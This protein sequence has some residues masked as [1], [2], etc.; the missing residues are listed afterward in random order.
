MQCFDS[1]IFFFFPI[2][3]LNRHKM[4]DGSDQENEE[5]VRQMRMLEEL[6]QL[7]T[8]C[9]ESIHDPVLRNN[10]ISLAS[11]FS[12]AKRLPLYRLLAAVEWKNEIVYKYYAILSNT[13]LEL[14]QRIIDLMNEFVS[15]S[16][17]EVFMNSFHSLKR[18]RIIE[19]LTSIKKDQ[20]HDMLQILRHST[21]SDIEQ[22]SDLINSL[23]FK[24][25][26]DMLQKARE[27]LS[28]KCRLCKVKRLKAL[29]TRLLNDQVPEGIMKTAG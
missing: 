29:E 16:L 14:V 21:A 4:V 10:L 6:D 17:L 22:T 15:L 27:P 18:E 25:L 2:C 19:L 26:F 20:T 24:E 23:S 9:K 7:E 28:D 12:G 8:T 1:F 13:P 5:W 11:K 3:E